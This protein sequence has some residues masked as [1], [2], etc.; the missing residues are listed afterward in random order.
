M[1][2]YRQTDS[3]YILLM[4]TKYFPPSAQY[5]ISTHNPQPKEPYT[6][7][8]VNC[9]R[10]AHFTCPRLPGSPA[11]YPHSAAAA[12][13]SP[14]RWR[15]CLRYH[16]WLSCSIVVNSDPYIVHTSL[17]RFG[18]VSN[19]TQYCK[20]K[21]RTVIVPSERFGLGHIWDLQLTYTLTLAA[22]FQS[23]CFI[24]WVTQIRW[25]LNWTIRDC[26]LSTHRTA[27]QY[28]AKRFGRRPIWYLDICGGSDVRTFE[29][30][31]RYLSW[32][33][34]RLTVR[35]TVNLNLVLNSKYEYT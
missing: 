30:F 7:N 16:S 3:R 19:F 34:L 33:L 4:Q 5:H 15:L 14:P 13:P 26:Q 20:V 11:S 32:D 17:G 6:G 28:Q 22:W 27:A 1:L 8:C 31:P 10:I 12:G 24:S 21:Y 25:V 9:T 35:F 18:D 2:Q 29:T 23:G